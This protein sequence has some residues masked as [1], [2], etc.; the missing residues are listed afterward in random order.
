MLDAAKAEFAR[1]GLAGGRVDAIAARA[2]ANKRMIYH[3]F[4]NKEG[5]YVAVLEDAY[6]TIRAAEQRLNL[7]ELPPEE[8]I[9]QLVTFTWSYFIRNPEFLTLV[10][11]ENLHRARYLKKSTV[12]RELHTPLI[13]MVGSILE[14]G[15]AAGVFR[16]GLDPVQV[17][18]TIAAVGY[19]YL[20]NRFTGS[21]IYDRDLN[22]REAL[23]ERLAFNVDTIMRLLRRD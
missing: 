10:N 2:K 8:A 16:D 6:G 3:Y 19:H 14:R 22:S 4:G 5:L 1:L 12:I 13:E 11:T 7:A 15:V 20:N 23:D 21:I 18:L 9:R 17:N